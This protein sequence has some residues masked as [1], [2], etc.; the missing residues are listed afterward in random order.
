MI[1][2]LRIFSL[3]LVHILILL[4]IFYWGDQVVGSVDFQEFFH[5][6]LKHGIINAGVLLVIIAFFI[7]RI[8]F[9]E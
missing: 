1:Q 7:K 2:K 5:S 4:H 9:K 6:F 8:Y 3:I